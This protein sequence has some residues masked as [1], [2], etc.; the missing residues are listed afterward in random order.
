MTCPVCKGRGEVAM[1]VRCGA[2][3][4]KRAMTCPECE[5][6]GERGFLFAFG[7]GFVDTDPPTDEVSM[8]VER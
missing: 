6:S 5:G 8:Q 2:E 4:Q 3:Y 1:M 7:G